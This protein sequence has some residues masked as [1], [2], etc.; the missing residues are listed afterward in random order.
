MEKLIAVLLLLL[1][2]SFQAQ[3]VWKQDFKLD[4]GNF[5]SEFNQ[6]FQGLNI[7]AY[8]SCGWEVSAKGSS[9]PQK[10][11]I[12][13]VVTVFNESKSWKH[14]STNDSYTLNHEQKH[15]DICE[16]YARKLRRE[17]SLNIKNSGDYEKYFQ[18][19]YDNTLQEYQKFQKLYDKETLHGLNTEQQEIYNH[20]IITDLEKLKNFA[21]P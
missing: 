17:I 5:K 11:V 19:I 3:I 16:L 15:F 12:I 9:N 20:K 8:A 6:E 1:F 4:W 2:T 13:E 21:K 7:A 10:P 18:K 14:P